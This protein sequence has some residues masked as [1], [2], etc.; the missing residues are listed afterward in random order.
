M[1]IAYLCTDI[2][3]RLLGK[4]GAS[5]HLNH[6]VRALRKLG[7]AVDVFSVSPDAEDAQARQQGVHHV[8]ML[9]FTGTAAMLLEQEEAGL[10]GHLSREWR[11][12]LYSEYCQ[13]ALLAP[14]RAFEPDVIY[15]RYSLFSY[16]GIALA[17]RFGIP[18]VLEVNAPLAHEAATHRELVLRRTAEALEREILLGSDALVVVSQALARYAHDLGVPSERITV[19]PNGVDPDLFAPLSGS[20]VRSRYQLEGREVLGFVGTLK[21][22]HDL[23]TVVEALGRLAARRPAVH[24]LVVGD[25]PG[26]SRLRALANDRVTCTGS[27]DHDD[28]PRFMAAMDVVVV[29]YGKDA[30]PYFSPLKLFEAMAMAK[31]IVGA[32]LGEV[33]ETVV[34]GETGLLYEPGCADDL[35]D[36]IATVLDTSQRGE[37]LGQAAR[38]SVLARHTW[39]HN[40]QR[41]IALAHS[42]LRQQGERRWA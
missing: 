9:G 38:R 32:R 10:P 33:A 12:L 19:M 2:G 5:A 14:L 28:V 3:I 21:P 7:H 40:A 26:G 31:P 34:D 4:S 11:R 37:Q 20:E 13:H 6:T 24:L 15:E 29:P 23:D 25:G 8:A 22:W 1:R 39:D 36:K 17:R 35:T 30:D 42:L 18:H 41:T 27:V 16:G